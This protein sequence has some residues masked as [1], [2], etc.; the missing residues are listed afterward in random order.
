LH[1][2]QLVHLLQQKWDLVTLFEL[3]KALT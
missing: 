2:E 1:F 3:C